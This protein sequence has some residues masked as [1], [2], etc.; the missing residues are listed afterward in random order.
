MCSSICAE[1]MRPSP[2]RAAKITNRVRVELLL[3]IKWKNHAIPLC[4][5]VFVLNTP[6]SELSVKITGLSRSWA[7][8]FRSLTIVGSLQPR[9]RAVSGRQDH[10]PESELDCGDQAVSV[11]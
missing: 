5:A 9:H 10:T 7:A 3:I 4:V 6:N 1:V 11:S 2:S 8:K